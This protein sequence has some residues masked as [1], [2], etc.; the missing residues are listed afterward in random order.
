MIANPKKAFQYSDLRI[1]GCTIRF[2]TEEASVDS[3]CCVCTFPGQSPALLNGC[4]S[5][6]SV[7]PGRAVLSAQNRFIESVHNFK[8][9]L[10]QPLPAFS[11]HLFRHSVKRFCDTSGDA[12]QS[13]TVSSK[14]YRCANHI[15]KVVSFHECCDCFRDSL[16]AGFH[17]MV[18]RPDLIAGSG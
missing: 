13:V 14:G 17:V 8:H 7:P 15:L 12:G 6:K 1:G 4:L 10:R 16:L 2:A 5:Q 3:S 11:L 18:G 9:I